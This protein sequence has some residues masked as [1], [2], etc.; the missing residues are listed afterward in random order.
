M[1]K[2]FLLAVVTALALVYPASAM[3]W[4][5]SN[6]TLSC[7]QFDFSVPDTT[8]S[9]YEYTITGPGL[10]LTGQLGAT[11]AGEYFS[12]GGV[13]A[14][15]KVTATATYKPDHSSASVT[16]DFINCTEPTGK[17]GPR[18]P[19][20][21]QGS[22]GPAGPTG[23]EGPAGPEGPKGPSGPEGPAG[24]TGPQGPQG[25]P[26]VTGAT[27]PEGPQG[28]QGDPGPEGPAGI[29][30]EPGLPGEPGA[31]G[32]TG[33]EGPQGPEGQGC[34][35]FS[36]DLQDVAQQV[37][38]LCVGPEGPA[39][40]QG[41]AGPAGPEGPQGI[42]GIPGVA[43]PVGPTGTTTTVETVVAPPVVKA[44][45]PKLPKCK[46]G[47]KRVTPKGPCLHIRSNKIK[48]KFTG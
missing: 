19:E 38:P 8:T 44:P 27:G 3:A 24:P 26:G 46:K 15:G 10:K 47:T 48:P 21:P 13:Y 30:G 17:E 5:P 39:G 36:E 14:N 7:G 11:T 25:E 28:P 4:T 45:A 31:T 32:A 20:G 16:Y 22:T 43:G 9:G 6:L 42:P 29:P 34:F 12:V 33:P 23:P 1:K 37:N 35:T 41:P 2:K 18:G 40:P